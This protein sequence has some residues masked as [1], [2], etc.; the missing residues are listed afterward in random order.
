[1]LEEKKVRRFTGK[2]V[3]LEDKRLSANPASKRTEPSADLRIIKSP[4]L[5]RNI[6]R[7]RKFTDQIMTSRKEGKYPKE[8]FIC[9]PKNFDARMLK[10]TTIINPSTQ[11]VQKLNEKTK[12]EYIS[13]A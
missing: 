8:C 11:P 3:Q 9:F 4:P 5:V 1:V 7:Y 10:K 2:K 13:G 12:G 6:F